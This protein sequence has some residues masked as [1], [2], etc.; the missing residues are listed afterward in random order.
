MAR[1]DDA[2]ALPQ[3]KG[4]DDLDHKLA[5]LYETL[6]GIA[7]QTLGSRKGERLLDPTELVHEC[8]IRL[9]RTR[10]SADMPRTELV[11]L[12][13]TAIRSILV[14]HSRQVASLKR[15]GGMNRVTLHAD[16]L[17]QEQPV[18]VLALDSALERLALLDPRMARV[19]ELRFFGGLTIEETAST[20][21]VRASAVESDWSLARAWLHRELRR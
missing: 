18:D 4:D 11:A 6:H 15:G 1:D 9:R 8:Y 19:V 3:S 5:E 14:D 10:L 13:A 20:L 7:R 12:A 2:S 21:G 17:A 16:Q